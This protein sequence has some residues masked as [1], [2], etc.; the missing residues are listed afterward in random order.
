MKTIAE[1]YRIRNKMLSNIDLIQA[2]LNSRADT[3]KKHI[4]A[5]AMRD[6]EYFTAEINQ[7]NS[8]IDKIV[9]QKI[10]KKKK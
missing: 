2:Q 6:I 3:G 10:A 4:R 1:L 7:I 8:L 9:E 5:I